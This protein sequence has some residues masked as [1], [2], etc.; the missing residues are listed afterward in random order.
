MGRKPLLK[1]N[2]VLDAINGWL[3][4]RGV[5]PTIEELRQALHVGSIRTVLRYLRM[6]EDEGEIRRWAGARGIQPLKASEAGQ[7]TIAV[8]VVG[9]APAGPLMIAEQNIDSWV[10]LPRE[11]IKPASA[12]YF[13]LRV[14]GDSMNKAAVA[15]AKIESGDLVLVRQQPTARPGDIVVA[16]IDGEATIKRFGRGPGYFVLKPESSNSKHHPIVLHEEFSTQG[17]VVQVLKKGSTLLA[18][19]GET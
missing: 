10:R 2:Q 5:P 8:P 3:V 18:P 12:K 4:R 6:L 13:L 17:V 15:G 11:S 19:T 1:R 16:L 9:E 7:E 14:R